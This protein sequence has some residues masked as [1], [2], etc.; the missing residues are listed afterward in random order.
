MSSIAVRWNRGSLRLC[1]RDPNFWDRP[2]PCDHHIIPQ[3]S[4]FPTFWPYHKLQTF[5]YR[6]KTRDNHRL[7]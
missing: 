1:W 5:K 7:V 3:L 4:F 2:N 6:W